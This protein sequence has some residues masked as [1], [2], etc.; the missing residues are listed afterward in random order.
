MS[1]KQKEKQSPKVTDLL[2]ELGKIYLEHGKYDKA[3]SKLIQLI[4]MEETNSNA[5]VHLS[6]AYI[7]KKQFDEEA[8]NILE[9]TL[10]YA[11]EN[12]LIYRVLSQMYLKK[13][14]LDEQA[15]KIYFYLIDQDKQNSESLFQKLLQLSLS[16]NK[17]ETTQRLMQQLETGSVRFWQALQLFLS[18]LW[19]NNKFENAGQFL[20][21][22][23]E[24]GQDNLFKRLF[25]FNLLKS[26]KAETTELKLA[27]KNQEFL[28]NFVRSKNSIEKLADVYLFLTINRLLKKIPV[29][30]KPPKS[31]KQI[32]EFELFL[33]GE[34]FTNILDRGLEKNVSTVGNAGVDF[35]QLWEKLNG[36][37]VQKTVGDQVEANIPK[38]EILSYIFDHSNSLIIIKM[39]EDEFQDVEKLLSE[40]IQTFCKKGDNPVQGFC[41]KDGLLLFGENVETL[42]KMAVD[43]IEKQS[44]QND[45]DGSKCYHADIVIHTI[46]LTSNRDFNYL[47]D[48]LEMAL[49]IFEPEK[50][51]F[52]D[53]IESNETI[54]QG[55]VFITSAVNNLIGKENTIPFTPSTILAEHP[56]SHDQFMVY[57][58]C[59]ENTLIKIKTG[60]VKNIGRYDLIEELQEN[61]IFASYKAIDTYLERPVFVKVLR[62]E[63]IKANAGF[64]TDEIFFNSMRL[65]GKLNHPD[66]ALIYDVGKE[67]NLCYFAREY[68]EGEALSI[69]KKANKQIDWGRAV[70]LGINIAEVLAHPHKSEIVHGR[71]KPN[72]IFVIDKN[73]IKLTDFQI[74]EAHIPV[75][76]LDNGSINY[77][78][79]HAPEFI[80]DNFNDQFSDIYSLGVILYE[81]LTGHNPFFF[82]EKQKIIDFV[83]YKKPVPITKHNSELPG[84]LNTIVMKAIEKEPKKRFTSISEF[85]DVLKKLS[86]H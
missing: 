32:E 50:Q 69:P 42:V 31:K 30:S 52:P 46:S 59:K 15:L 16:K 22:T 24:S 18:E 38:Q 62:P 77:L 48:D 81:L 28:I 47:V 25:I 71:L 54:N 67:H 1:K 49:N 85:R 19:K 56:V 23:L 27:E 60:D 43:F 58:L 74:S 80:K 44:A 20:K 2:L 72:N 73:S 61:E 6:K 17:L 35:N 82:Q 78:S 39:K 76:Q 34:S 75:Q 13:E 11:P 4:Q 5:Y 64:V 14:K 3:I 41:T 63:F 83:L 12:I 66:I 21:A 29:K 65:L 86:L 40:S 51:L 68:I 55:R 84:E 53:A 26:I 36:W 37:H 33:S 79:Y 10:E 7:L 45:K 57:E 8:Q 9:K 70:Q